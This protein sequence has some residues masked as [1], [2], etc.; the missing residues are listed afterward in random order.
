MACLT[1]DNTMGLSA[2]SAFLS[3]DDYTV[4]KK[5][6][7]FGSNAAIYK[8]ERRPRDGDDDVADGTRPNEIVLKV[9]TPPASVVNHLALLNEEVTI[10]AAVQG[11]ASILGFYGV[12]LMERAF[13][14]NTRWAIQMEHCSGGDLW[15]ATSRERYLETEARGVISGILEGLAHMHELGFVHR[16][17]KPEN[18]LLTKGGMVKLADFGISASLTDQEAM[19]RKCG[20]PGYV[21]PEILLGKDYGVKV[22]TFSCGSVLHFIVAGKTPFSGATLEEVMRKTIDSAPNFRRSVRLERLSA[23]CK[24]FMNTLLCKN[25]GDRPTASEALELT[26]LKESDME[27]TQDSPRG[28]PTCR[29]LQEQ[30]ECSTQAESPKSSTSPWTSFRESVETTGDATMCDSGASWKATDKGCLDPQSPIQ[31]NRMHQIL[32]DEMVMFSAEVHPAPP[33]KAR[34]FPAPPRTTHL[35]T[36][37]GESNA[38]KSQPTKPKKFMLLNRIRAMRFC[39]NSSAENHTPT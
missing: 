21:A 37:S 5:P 13:D 7:A 14:G 29:S 18:I 33:I 12:C 36:P 1:D 32:K 19:K 24:A 38:D 26:W 10:L 25:P 16:D 3:L 4:D 20:S 23:G 30:S 9:I 6:M 34:Q 28:S 15:N 2:G 22:D 27:I 35:E 8:G 31:A 39:S 17:V 11:H